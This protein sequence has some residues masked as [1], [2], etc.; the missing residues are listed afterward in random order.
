MVPIGQPQTISFIGQATH[1]GGSCQIA[2]TTDTPPTKKSEFKVIRSIEGG[3]P[4]TFPGNVGD[5][6][7]LKGADKFNYTLPESIPAGRNYT[8]AW[9]WYVRF[10]PVVTMP[11]IADGEIL[12]GSTRLV[13]A[14][15]I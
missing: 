5:S 14:R 9:T 8:L 7:F 6:P 11:E 2:L 12:I 3:C 1:G 4:S 15:C 10:T 13:I